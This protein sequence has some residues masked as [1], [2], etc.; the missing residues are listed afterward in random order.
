MG[1]HYN[2][3]MTLSSIEITDIFISWDLCMLIITHHNF[4]I[5]VIIRLG[6]ISCYVC[7]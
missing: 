7:K 1:F 3:S 2:N 6:A 4:E 5:M